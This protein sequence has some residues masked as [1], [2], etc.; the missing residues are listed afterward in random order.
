[1]NVDDI[2]GLSRHGHWHNHTQPTTYNQCQYNEYLI[3]SFLFQLNKYMLL[4]H[5]NL[6]PELTHGADRQFQ[7]LTTRLLMVNFLTSNLNRF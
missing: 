4:E 1:M 7:L 6:V 5:V 3:H 2:N